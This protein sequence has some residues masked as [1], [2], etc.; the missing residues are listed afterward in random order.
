MYDGFSKENI[1]KLPLR[2]ALGIGILGSTIAGLNYIG[3]PN[4]FIVPCV[5]LGLWFA[6]NTR[7]V[8]L[9]VLGVVIPS[10]F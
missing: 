3:L 6:C 7:S 10:A 1:R 5:T 8:G 2:L 9:A 4:F